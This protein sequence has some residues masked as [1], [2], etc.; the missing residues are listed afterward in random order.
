MG[1]RSIGFCAL[2]IRVILERIVTRGIFHSEEGKPVSLGDTYH[3]L[4]GSGIG[5]QHTGVEGVVDLICQNAADVNGAHIRR[6]VEIGGEFEVDK[7]GCS[8]HTVPRLRYHRRRLTR[9]RYR[10]HKI[11]LSKIFIFPIVEQLDSKSN[12]SHH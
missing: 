11:A 8:I 6:N 4:P 5:D 10:F 3:D 12:Q 1:G 9:L 2:Q 7:T